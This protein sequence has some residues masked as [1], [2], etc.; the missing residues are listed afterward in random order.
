MIHISKKAALIIVLLFLFCFKTWAQVEID[1]KNVVDDIKNGTTYVVYKHS[2]F[3]DS[4]KDLEVFNQY[5]TVTKGT[6]FIKES[7]IKNKA[8]PGDSFFSLMSLTQRS[9]AGALN[10][11]FFIF[12]WV[13]KKS[14]FKK[15][16]DPKVSDMNGVGVIEVTGNL[17]MVQRTFGDFERGNYKDTLE[18]K[19]ARIINLNPGMLKIYL[20]QLTTTLKAGTKVTFRDESTNKNQL[21]FLQTQMLY[22]SEADFDRISPFSRSESNLKEADKIFEDYKYTYKILPDDDLS[23]M[24]L[25]E[26]KPFYF[27]LFVRSAVGK[28]VNVINAQTG[29]IIY[30]RHHSMSFNLKSGDL[31]SLYKEIKKL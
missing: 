29:E 25:N 7:D 30:S 26:T 9:T 18:T 20:Q 27:L 2:A 19:G 4:A 13:P 15:N 6:Q 5:W 11:E 21:K 31:E 12:L 10:T 14:Y 23:E 17:K 3:P 28:L 24:I 8:L 22:V 1:K 16:R